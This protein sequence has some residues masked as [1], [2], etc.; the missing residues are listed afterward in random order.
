MRHNPI[1]SAT[2]RSAAE[3]H[4]AGE[5][6][7]PQRGAGLARW[8]GPVAALAAF[9]LV[10]Y[11][12]HAELA[13]LHVRVVLAQL[14]AV[15]RSALT[16]GFAL[17]AGSYAALCGYDVLALRYL[18]KRVPWAR[19]LSASFIA[20]AFGHNLGFGA[21]TG[22]AFRLRLYASSGLTATDV[23][24]VTGYTSFTTMLGLAVLAGTSFAAAPGR[25]AAALHLPRSGCLV[26][27][28]GMLAAAAAYALWSCSHRIRLEIRG[29]LLRAP[30][31]GLG[32]AQIVLATL[33]L[34][35]TAAVLWVLLPH[36][37]AIGYVSFAGLF[38]V[39]IA[40]G[41]V[42][43]L[44]GGI[45]AFE[46]VIVFALPEVPPDALLGSLLAYRFVY[47][48]T[49]LI[50]ATLL[51]GAE[52]LGAQRAR[53][54][55]ARQQAAAFVAP[56]VP[57]IVGAMTFVAGA[58]LLASGATPEI[59]TR[60]APLEG[61][62]PLAVV[63]LSHL[64]G[65][66]IGLALLILARALFR[67]IRAAYHITFWLLVAGAAAS[68]LKGFDYEEA[69][70]LGVVLI[71]LELGRNGFYRRASILEQRFT[72]IWMASVIGVVAASVW[73]GLTTYRHIEYSSDLW[74]TFAFDANAPRMLRASLVVS[75]L[76]G[77]YLSLNLLRPSARRPSPSAAPAIDQIR[78]IVERSTSTLACAALA[79]DK[80]LL[81]SDSGE[82]FLMYQ[83]RGRSWIGLGDP[84]GPQH[85]AEELVW[86]FRELSDRHGGRV[87]F[88]QTGAEHLSLYLDLGLAALKIGEDA[89]VPLT[90]FP[91]AGLAGELLE[92]RRRAERDGLSFGVIPREE[93]PAMLPALRGI[94]EAW[95]ESRATADRRPTG[96]KRF[97]VGSFSEPYLRHFPIGLVRR[98]ASP[99]AFANLWITSG[100]EEIAVDLLR[101]APQAPPGTMD[102]LLIELM[103]WARVEGIRWFDLGVAPLPG[104]ERH[105]LSPAWRRIG[106]L[107]FRHGE[108]FD[109]LESLRQY[110]AKFHPVWEPTYLVA[111][112][113]VALP[114]VLVDVSALIAGGLK[115]L[116]A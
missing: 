78:R 52:E 1:E 14:H 97:S 90:A 56:A 46:A 79:G 85:E 88:Y 84:I 69:I 72:P 115:E 11:L 26:A 109:D 19:M 67:R 81:I 30:G 75:I 41:L 45:G 37:A 80:R 96:E 23:A 44:P 54:A 29:W 93:V 38:S 71:V 102:Y 64:A 2:S 51:F 8:V 6:P 55:Q 82:S 25:A 5:S 110:K 63:E 20:N 28:V 100:R 76:A 60:L 86:R 83:V 113:G 32:A 57:A 53:L 12:L 65:S 31:A 92:A 116:I 112:G 62:L 18:R 74:W 49:P 17:T 105:P 101:F 34:G 7:P 73:I 13:H 36:S 24:M 91:D 40:A 58:V 10:A 70:M 111:R 15:P 43:H 114:L 108:H 95:L 22:G 103:L 89:R 48:L 87:V 99:V 4:R 106:P 3:A 104:L 68:L 16:A 98:H 35:C 77:A 66:I 33:D 59:D 94:S 27:G 47:F 42:T 50:F 39:A 9:A 61:L 21:F 107:V